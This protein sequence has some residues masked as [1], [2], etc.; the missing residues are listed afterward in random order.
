MRTLRAVQSAFAYFSICPVSSVPQPPDADALSM[1]PL[2]GGVIGA[3]SGGLCYLLWPLVPPAI[4]VACA[5]VAPIFLSGA[6]HIDGF[7]D[8]CDALFA[9]VSVRRRFEIMKE[10]A[11]GSF[12]L[13]G[14]AIVSVAW[15]SILQSC[16]RAELAQWL[17]LAL[18]LSRAAV[19]P[20]TLVVPYARGGRP[21]AGWLMC[22][23][24]VALLLA[25]WLN[26][27]DALIPPV[28]LGCALT[29]GFAIKRRL[30]GVLVGDSYGFLIVACEIIALLLLAVVQHLVVQRV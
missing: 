1:L 30:G 21:A 16:G 5:F 18:L 9:T 24:A 12:A 7:A 22:W 25:F 20:L 10:P 28:V 19:L 6:I 3:C 11:R 15:W 17:I 8:S 27:W 23:F 2:V 14:M 4:A 29:G 26:P 13:A